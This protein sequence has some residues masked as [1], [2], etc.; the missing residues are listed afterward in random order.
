MQTPSK[1][2]PLMQR[3][4][5]L[6]SLSSMQVFVVGRFTGASPSSES[7]SRLQA[8]STHLMP[9]LQ[10]VSNTQAKAEVEVRQR[11]VTMIRLR[12]V[13]LRSRTYCPQMSEFGQVRPVVTA[14]AIEPWNI[15]LM[16][17]H[18]RFWEQSGH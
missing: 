16:S 2:V 14:V 10:S 7:R 9:G 12:T 15:P 3:E 4:P 13:V 17:I 11:I 18:A 8:P 5:G 1:P 6:Q